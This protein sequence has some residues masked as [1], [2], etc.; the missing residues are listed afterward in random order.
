MTDNVVCHCVNN[1]ISGMLEIKQRNMK[2]IRYPIQ[3][4][5]RYL[6]VIE[7]KIV[8]ISK[9]YYASSQKNSLHEMLTAIPRWIHQFSSDHWS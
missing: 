4:K 5:C 9:Q 1:N 7:W 8:F 6:I 2:D 3:Y